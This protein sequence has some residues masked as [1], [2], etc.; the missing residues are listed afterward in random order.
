[1]KKVEVKVEGIRLKVA[2]REIALTVEEAKKLKKALDDLF[3]EKPILGVVPWWSPI[4]V[5]WYYGYY[6]PA[7][8][9]GTGG[10]GAS[11]I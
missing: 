6:E 10:T 2:K 11:T 1:M 9:S 7:W 8:D 3:G 5:P 4:Y